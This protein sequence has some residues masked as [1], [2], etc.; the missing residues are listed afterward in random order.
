M[1]YVERVIDCP[2]LKVILNE[3]C[4]GFGRAT[5]RT[6]INTVCHTSV[7]DLLDT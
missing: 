2:I 6:P 7:I 4:C 5:H 1:H 3:L